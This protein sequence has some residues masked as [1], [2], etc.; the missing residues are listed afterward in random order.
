MPAGSRTWRAGLGHFLFGLSL[1]I[2]AVSLSGCDERRPASSQVLG[3]ERSA[4]QIIVKIHGKATMVYQFAGGWKPYVKEYR[5]TAGVNVIR[6]SPPDH[7]HH[8]GIMFA[9]TVN[10]VNFWEEQEQSGRQEHRGL[11]PMAEGAAAGM[12]YVSFGQD[13]AWIRPGDPV[14]LLKETRRVTMCYGEGLGASLADWRS[15]LTVPQGREGV[16]LSGP[17]Y[18]GLG[19]RFVTSMDRMGQFRNANDKLDVQGTDG[20]E[21]T[22]TAYSGPVGWRRV[23]TV[24]VFGDPKNPPLWF[25]LDQPFAYLAA[26]LG[27]HRRQLLLPQNG[28]LELR[29]GLAVWDANPEPARVRA[30]YERWQALVQTLPE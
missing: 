28:G 7:P 21:A 9:V 6:D 25:T 3:V 24:A 13:L 4:Y 22:W 16:V 29:Y 14:P 12:S 19:V 26:T 23:A 30:L 17:K 2:C 8:H 20:A 27:L 10:G 5:N 1:T 15:V 11:L 18:V